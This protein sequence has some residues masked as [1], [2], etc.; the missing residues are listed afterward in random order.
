[1]LGASVADFSDKLDFRDDADDLRFTE[2][3]FLHTE[4]S[5]V[6]I[7]YFGM[8]RRYEEAS[9]RSYLENLSRPEEKNP[10]ARVYK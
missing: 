9:P 6:W 1:M 2:T 4:I 8:E 10:P 3:G 7:I 5:V